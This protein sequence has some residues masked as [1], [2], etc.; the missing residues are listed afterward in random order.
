LQRIRIHIQGE[1]SIVELEHIQ[2]DRDQILTI[3]CIQHC[4]EKIATGNISNQVADRSARGGRSGA[5]T[6]SSSATAAGSRAWSCC[7]GGRTSARRCS[8]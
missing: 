3:P 7:T 4:I 6:T 1:A 5:C 2:W 8:R